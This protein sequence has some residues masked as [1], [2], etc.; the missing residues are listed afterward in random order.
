VAE[1]FGDKADFAIEAGVE[2]GLHTDATVWGHMCVWCRG[3][4]LGDL[5]ERYCALHHA[6]TEFAWRADNLDSLWADELAGL[7]DEAAWNVLDGLLYSCH[8]DVELA[9]ARTLAEL[10]WDAARWGRFNFLTNWGE[11]FDGYKSF[12]LCPPGESARVLSRRL[13]SYMGRGVSVSRQGLV[14]AAAGFAAWFESESRRLG[15]ACERPAK[16]GPAADR[17]L[18]SE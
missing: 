4:P 9:D 15:V 5:D 1:V 2:P 11:Q 12:L 17:D 16:P 13:P 10:Q 14:A 3:V 8:G 18:D 7:D 6:Y